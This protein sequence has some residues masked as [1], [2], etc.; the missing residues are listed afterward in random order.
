MTML[1]KLAAAAT[2][3]LLPLFAGAVP[4]GAQTAPA[5]AC[6][7]ADVPASTTNAVQ[8][9]TPALSALYHLSGTAYVQVDLDAGGAILGTSIAK[10]SGYYALDRAALE[11]ARESTFQPAIHD[12]APVAGS[13]LYVVDFPAY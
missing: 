8:P 6:T 10:T 7:A 4:G 5:A 2:V 9:D 12:C 11:A 1:T 3:A 13:Y